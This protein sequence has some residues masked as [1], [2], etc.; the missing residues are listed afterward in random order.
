M[1]TCPQY[2]Y[3]SRYR[4]WSEKQHFAYQ[5]RSKLTPAEEELWDHLTV[6][7]TGAEFKS[8]QV[9][10]GWIVDFLAPHWK[11]VVEVD[12]SIHDRRKQQDA[13]R[14]A[15]LS[16]RGYTVIRFS[17]KAVFAR[18]DLVIEKIVDALNKCGMDYR[19]LDPKWRS[20]KLAFKNSISRA[21]A[22]YQ[23]NIRL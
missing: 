15:T 10:Y 19:Y 23:R 7:E 14:D 21:L 8:Q 9:L 2:P 17:N 13:F 1:E 16:K 4:R 12:G 22:T 11:L 6:E 5:L 20:K 18:V 3:A